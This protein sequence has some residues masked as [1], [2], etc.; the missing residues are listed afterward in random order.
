MIALLRTTIDERTSPQDLERIRQNVTDALRE[1]Q[2]AP[3]ARARII[4][5]IAL[6]DG[7]ATPIAHG[8]GRPAFVTHSPPRGATATGRIEEVRD[9]SHDRTKYVV[10]K[11]TGFVATITID[12]EVK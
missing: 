6:A 1:L 2:Q 3:A 4:R 12:L 8:L 10:L 9:G 7:V 11:A 5:D